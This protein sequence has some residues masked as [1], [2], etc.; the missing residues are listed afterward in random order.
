MINLIGAPIVGAISDRLRTRRPLMFCGAVG[1]MIF[2]AI[3]L[4]VPELSVTAIYTVL[5]IIGL[6]YGTQVLI[7]AFSRDIT[8]THATATVVAVT[9]MLVMLG[10]MFLQP[11]VG[12][13]LEY[14]WSG[15]IVS[16]LHVYSVFEYQVALTVM[17]LG[18]ALAAIL[19]L[20][21]R[22]NVGHAEGTKGS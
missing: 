12:V 15:N 21:L 20:F 16:H 2:S 6:M 9:N 8:P 14:I 3:F 18:A 11:T 19:S 10:G 17:P 5:F 7:F 13:V 1:T 4:Y 22:D